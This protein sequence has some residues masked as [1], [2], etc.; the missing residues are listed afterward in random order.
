M[1]SELQAG[2]FR[3]TIGWYMGFLSWLFGLK[4]RKK[5][6]TEQMLDELTVDMTKSLL[7]SP[8]VVVR[9]S[10]QKTK[11]QPKKPRKPRRSK[12]EIEAER[13][14]RK[15]WLIKH[16]KQRSID[17]RMR[18]IGLG[19][20]HYRW[21]TAGDERTCPACAANDGKIFSWNEPPPKTGHPGEGRCCVDAEG[22]CRC[23]ALAHFDLEA[24]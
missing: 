4:P 11:S 24:E 17:D 6:T 1:V 2:R 21:Q 15:Q 7:S 8:R 22:Y 10:Q 18:Q 23:V 16:N 14:Q 12:E 20:T 19:I 3:E 5:K 13:A 9:A